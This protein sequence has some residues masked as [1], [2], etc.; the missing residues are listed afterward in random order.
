MAA[1]KTQLKVHT[2]E[3]LKDIIA[4]YVAT[5]QKHIRVYKVILF[6][7]Y[8]CGTPRRESDIDLAV[9]SPDFNKNPLEE[10]YLLSQARAAASWDIEALPYS[11]QQYKYCEPGSF[12]HEII[13]TGAVMYDG[14]R[15]D[16]SVQE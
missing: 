10:L 12:L 2:S 4:R 5:L 14:E 1:T 16:R 15:T 6:G 11:L 13:R 7:S 3:E 8:A 9:I